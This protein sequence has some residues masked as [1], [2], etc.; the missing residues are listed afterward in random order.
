MLRLR[1]EAAAAFQRPRPW[2]EG[3]YS[4]ADGDYL[5]YAHITPA[6]EKR[7]TVILTSGYSSYKELHYETISRFQ[8]MGLE[9]YALDWRGHG[10]SEGDSQSPPQL[11]EKDLHGF[12][13]KVVR[14]DA[15]SPL[16]LATHSM[17]GHVGLR[18][19]GDQPGIFD[20]VV[21]ANP[22]TNINTF[23]RIGGAFFRAAV[24]IADF[25]GF[26]TWRPPNIPAY[27]KE[28]KQV[29]NWLS[30]GT[31]IRTREDAI[32]AIRMTNNV[33][34]LELP[35]VKFLAGALPSIDQTLKDSFLRAIETP[36]LIASGAKDLV[37]DNDSHRYVAETLPN[38][39]LVV[40][41]D[42]GHSAWHT[43]HKD[44]ESWWS[45]VRNFFEEQITAFRKKPVSAQR[46][47]I[48][49]APDF[50]AAA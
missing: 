9:V 35:T 31:Y 46:L 28:I 10:L 12:I 48:A 22:M 38:G 44:Y 39:K 16:F 1:D 25:L 6:G 32:E 17:G 19:I 49:P 2:Q 5:R 13:Q 21:M 30:G 20:G 4:N 18:Y 8:A 33:K 14:P 40:L 29:E 15:N 37:V 36:V 27:L 3:L 24:G 43:T 45:N 23:G 50:A 11:H 7:G 26:D 42:T 41:P 34:D 47:A